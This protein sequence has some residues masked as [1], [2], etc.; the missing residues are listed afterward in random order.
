MPQ[1]LR[2][3]IEKEIRIPKS[4][5]E[6]EVRADTF[7]ENDRTVEVCWSTGAK[8]KRYS[9]DEG[10]YMEELQVDK[11]AVRLDRF[12]AMSLLDTHDNYSMDSRLGTVVPGSVRFENGK[13][14]ARIKFSRKQRA[15][16]IMQ[17][18][19]DG[20][21]LP[22]SVGYKIHRYEKTEGA[23]GQLPVLRAIDW[24]PLELSAVP[25]PADA[26]AISRSEPDGKDF[27]TVL[28]RQDSP[29]A[30]VPATTKERPMN[31]REAAKQYKGDQLDALAIGAGI[32]RKENETDEA[33][34][35]RLL[36]AF[37][38]EDR[39]ADEAEKARKA[40]EETA[41]RAAEEEIQRRATGQQHQQQP[42]GL[43]EQQAQQRADE[44]VA[45][46]VKRR[47]DIEGFAKISGLKSDDEL[48]R[49]AIDDRHTMEQFRNAVL[50][51]MIADQARSPTFPHSESRG[52]DAQ[53]TM[54]R[55]VTNAILHQLG[56]ESKL[57]DGA[58]EWRS[59][60]AMEMARELLA[61]RGQS[62]RG[63]V[64][65]IAERSL[66]TTSDF[67][68]ILQSVVRAVLLSRYTGYEN[69]FQLFASREVLPDYREAKVLDIGA[70]PDLKLK[71]EHGEFVSGTLRESEEAMKLQRYG[72]AIGFTHEM[73]VNDQLGQF[74]KVVGQWGEKVAKLEGDVM[75]GAIINNLVM[76]DGFGLFHANHKNLA[77]SGTALD[78]ANLKKARTAMRGQ[79]DIDGGIINL[80][81][82]YL[83]TGSNLE[84][85]AQ[86][87]V[88][89]PYNPVVAGEV[90]PQAI[91][92]LVPVYEPRLDLITKNAWFLFS[93]SASDRG[94]HYLHLLGYEQ[95]TTNEQIGFRIEGVEFTIAHSFGVG[96]TD[97]RFAYKNPG[98]D[99]T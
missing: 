38:K 9:W 46:E 13:A 59:M 71:N 6:V 37:D 58:R 14:Y 30:A 29:H 65:Q 39:A 68:I 67:P 4:F 1:A 87:L 72:R 62:T 47:S 27:E 76:K 34:R 2:E 15:E 3:A 92:S 36:D 22:I 93:D 61:A 96:L 50:D 85:D 40:A 64:H 83:F 48:V 10:Y 63:G 70:A 52:M 17:D 42:T 19:R 32:S 49:K 80:N 25:I 56:V 95:P 18:I 7:N 11:K 33:L 44:A 8:V 16:E 31:K 54:R 69:T 41:R 28:V 86:T 82:K 20:H 79:K 78:I 5:G 84:L 53:D 77:A 43:T 98:V 24:E 23:D 94:L 51:K 81:P 45:A 12:S 91:K 35:A 75:W 73:L 60:G 57:E 74:M 66:H 89:A 97:Y 55:M 26:G 88:A 99:P 21:P 90:T